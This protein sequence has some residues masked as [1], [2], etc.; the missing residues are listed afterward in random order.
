MAQLD[1][2][3]LKLHNDGPHHMWEEEVT[4]QDLM[5]ERLKQAPWLILSIGLHLVVFLMLWVLIPPDKKEEV[6]NK[7]EMTQQEVVEQ[8]EPP[9]PPPPPPPL[10]PPPPPPPPLLFP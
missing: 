6:V 9:P 5:A 3:R 8:V 2:N 1:L 10:P 7:V 4:F